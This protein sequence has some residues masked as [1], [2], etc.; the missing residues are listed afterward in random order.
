MH[1]I[2]I[3]N[4]RNDG[5]KKKEYNNA[6]QQ[7]EICTLFVGQVAFGTNRKMEKGLFVDGV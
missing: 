4:I 2:R 3:Y 1:N 7:L 5:I 6:P